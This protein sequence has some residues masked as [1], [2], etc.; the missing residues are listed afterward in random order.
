[1]MWW[2][3]Q[4]EDAVDCDTLASRADS[5]ATTLLMLGVGERLTFFIFSLLMRA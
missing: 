4:K 1:M 2:P 3:P 5:L